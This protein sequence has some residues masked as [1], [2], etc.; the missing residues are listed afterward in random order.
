MTGPQALATPGHAVRVDDCWNRIGVRGDGSCTELERHSHCRN[1]PVF[2][3]AAAVLLDGEQSLAYRQEWT[4]HLVDEREAG[5]GESLSIVVFRVGEEWLAL[6]TAV[7]S[8]VVATRSVHPMA[9]QRS[10]IMRG[11]VSVR[12]ELV[13]C[14]SVADLLGIEEDTKAAKKQQLTVYGRMLVIQGEGGRFVFP[15]R[16]VH[17]IVRTPAG[18]LKEVPATL[19]GAA[20]TYTRAIVPWENRTVGLLDEQLLFYTLNRSLA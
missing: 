14:V 15:V 19:A 11:L 3:S 20:T 17:G 2:A 10:G 1:C 9:R 4:R 12:G 7:L 18:G 16:E 8:E 6:P 5:G 13:L